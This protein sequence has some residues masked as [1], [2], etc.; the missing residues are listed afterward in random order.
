MNAALQAGEKLMFFEAV[1]FVHLRNLFGQALLF[2]TV[3]T[4]APYL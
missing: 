3:H 2:C 1:P 4:R